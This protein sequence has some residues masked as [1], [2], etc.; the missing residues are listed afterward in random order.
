MA[1]GEGGRGAAGGTEGK[2]ESLECDEIGRRF[3]TTNSLLP[4]SDR[5][6]TGKLQ[7]KQGWPID[8]KRQNDSKDAEQEK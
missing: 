2:T 8:Q 6:A 4:C 3:D 5:Y 1:G 7:E